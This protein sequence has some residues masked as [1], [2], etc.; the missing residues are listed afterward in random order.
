MFWSSAVYFP[1][2]PK[3]IRIP[4]NRSKI[5]TEDVLYLHISTQQLSILLAICFNL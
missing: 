1:K 2:R 3:C 5:P 4:I